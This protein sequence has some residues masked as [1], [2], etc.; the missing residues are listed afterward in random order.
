MSFKKSPQAFAASVNA[1]TIGTND[2]AVTLGG[3]NVFPFYT[4]DAP[5]ANKPK[6]GVEIS[7]M[8]VN[9]NIPGIAKYYEGAETVVDMAKKAAAM[10]GADFLVISL[11]GA[12][13]TVRTVR[14]RTASRFAKRSQTLLMSP[15]SS[16]AAK[17][18][19]R[20]RSCLIK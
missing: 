9:K 17:T 13:P 1:V 5:I 3:E 14:S 18:R 7:D 11:E 4:F 8:G 6:I 15:L 2:K 12:N 19:K 20:T 16:K 10:P